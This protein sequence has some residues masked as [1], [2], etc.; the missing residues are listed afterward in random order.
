MLLGAKADVIVAI[1]ENRAATVP[2][3]LELVLEHAGPTLRRLIVVAFESLEPDTLAA[4]TKLARCDPRLQLLWSSHDEKFVESCNRALAEREGDAVIL[5]SDCAVSGDWL[6]ELA[7]VA[8]A[9]ERTACAAPLSNCGGSCSVPQLFVD[10]PSGLIDLASV[11]R[12][13]AGLP[14]WTVAPLLGALCIY[15]RGDV[16]D[17]VG[18]LDESLSSPSAAINDWV[19]RAQS[20]G[21]AAKRCN[22]VYVERLG[23][24]NIGQ[25][26]ALDLDVSL[27]D[28]E[29][30]QHLR[31]QIENFRKSLD[32]HL[33]AHAVQT[34]TTENLRVALDLRHLPREQTGTRTYAVSLAHA[35]GCLPDL[36]LTLLVRDASQAAGLMGRAVTPEQWRDDVQVIHKPAQVIE[37]SELELLFGSSAHLVVTYQDMIGY[38]IPLVFPD[39]AGFDRYRSTS[40]LTLPAVQRILAYSEN[41][42]N[43]IAAEF[44]IPRADIAVVPLGVEARWFA[45]TEPHDGAIHRKLRLPDRYFFSLATDFP[46]KNLPNL[47]D[48]YAIMRSRWRD[49][50]PPGL[51][52]A[53]FRTG[54]RRGIY[55]ELVSKAPGKGLVFLGPVSRDQLRVLYQRAVALVFPSLYEGFGLPPLEA[56]AAGTPV[57]AMPISAIP[58][59]GGDC[60]LY[61]DG[62]SPNSLAGSMERLA[63]DDALRER[64]RLRG[65]KRV[66]E[67]RWENTARSTL[68]VYRSA[69]RQPSDRSLQMR[70]LLRDAIFRWAHRPTPIQVGDSLA[71]ASSVHRSQYE[72]SIGV[73]NAW[74]ALNVAV[75]A[76]LSRELR[77]LPLAGVHR[78]PAS[79]VSTPIRG[80]SLVPGKTI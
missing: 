20:L 69:V 76:R 54:G 77:R 72:Q 71:W 25:P 26:P 5:R 6:L 27:A 40:S 46:H 65:L 12:A 55:P 50:E 8:H 7:V 73:K 41:A 47:L 1:E 79:N 10:A 21:F 23:I 9:E 39:D 35:L 59:V 2:A 32:G 28:L 19:L 14:R 42:G 29:Q 62:L 63:T 38:Q 66:E 30:E 68:E 24:D 33:A 57:I 17:A 45:H 58:E 51:V 31:H 13:C 49:G 22:H 75:S 74:K 80:K 36:D 70:R 11:R 43:E 4:L 53:G 61:P 56:M 37:T 3:C 78:K 64:L 44:G 34:E 18:L 67:F 16:L 60:V 52:L 48:A 15:L